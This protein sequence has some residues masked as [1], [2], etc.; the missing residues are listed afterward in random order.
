MNNCSNTDRQFDVY[1]D[2]YES[3]GENSETSLAIVDELKWIIPE[4]YL[5]G[6]I[7]DDRF[8]VQ[9]SLG[10][11]FTGFVRSGK[12]YLLNS[13]FKDQVFISNYVP[14]L[15][16][17]SGIDLKTGEEV[18][19]KFASPKKHYSLEKEFH[20]YL[21]LGADGKYLSICLS[22][23][24]HHLVDKFFQILILYKLEYHISYILETLVDTKC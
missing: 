20:N 22:S 2:A 5:S 10:D 4:K 17:Q 12:Y 1:D 24:R 13:S 14:F 21:Y 23:Y 6:V 8:L 18:A 7:I 9:E 3:N 11:G 16:L 15:Q 19:I